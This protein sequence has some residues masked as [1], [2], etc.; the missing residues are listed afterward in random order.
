MNHSIDSNQLLICLAS[1]MSQAIRVAEGFGTP[2]PNGKYTVCLA[3][4]NTELELQASKYLPLN[5]VT[6]SDKSKANTAK[7]FLVCTPSGLVVDRA[8]LRGGRCSE[9]ST[10]EASIQESDILRGYRDHPDTHQ[11]ALFVD[12]GFRGSQSLFANGGVGAGRAPLAVLMPALVQHSQQ[13]SAADVLRSQV[14]CSVWLPFLSS[15]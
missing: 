8:W 1:I 9:N 6:Y 3:A 2:T 11:V 7:L 13:H 4:D 14:L 10:L 12:R 5:N 15:S